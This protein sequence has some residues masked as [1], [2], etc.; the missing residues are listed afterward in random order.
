MADLDKQLEEILIKT[1]RT[2]KKYQ[3]LEP[4]KILINHQ[5]LEVH[6]AT[7]WPSQ[8]EWALLKQLLKRSQDQEPIGKFIQDLMEALPK[9]GLNRSL[10][11]GKHQLLVF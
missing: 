6:L 5:L 1:L 7:V 9:R 4:T 8:I 2:N 10:W 11:L 3:D